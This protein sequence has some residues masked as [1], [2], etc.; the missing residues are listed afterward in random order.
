MMVFYAGAACCVSF[1]LVNAASFIFGVSAENIG[2][3]LGGIVLGGCWRFWFLGS[4]CCIG[5]STLGGGLYTLVGGLVLFRNGG[6]GWA[7]LCFL[8]TWFS[9]PN[10]LLVSR[11]V[12]SALVRL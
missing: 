11:Y 4:D 7:I 9:A 10:F 6:T 2:Y 12:G 3:R 1:T 5:L 8:F